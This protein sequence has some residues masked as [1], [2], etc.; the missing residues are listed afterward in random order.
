MSPLLKKDRINSLMK[1]MKV[2]FKYLSTINIF[3]KFFN[4]KYVKTIK[5]IAIYITNRVVEKHKFPFSLINKLLT[6]CKKS[7]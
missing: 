1:L 3:F 7:K 5:N 6:F 4:V 2:S